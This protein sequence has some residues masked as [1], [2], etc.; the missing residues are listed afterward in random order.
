MTPADI[1]GLALKNAGV[2]GVGQTANAEDT[3]DAFTLLNMMLSQWQR[4]RWLIW[5]LV[6]TSKVSTGAQSY[7][8]G[9]GG[10]YNIARPDR[11]EAAFFRQENITLAPDYPLEILEAREDY[12]RI[13]LKNLTAFPQYIFYD[14]DFPLGRIYPWPIPQANLYSVHITTKAEL[15][16]FTS[17]SQSINLPPEY[18]AAIFYNLSV[19][20]R[21]MYQLQPD[22]TITAMA[23]DAL[24]VIRGANT[25]IPR[26]VM[27]DSLVN[28][29]VY[30]VYSDRIQ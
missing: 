30:D 13:S 3:N 16:Q 11:I 8:V 20:L 4:K 9:T 5:H 17:L 14:A 22:P 29:G 19:R 21:P 1:I 10:D 26:L 28:A 27:P 15:S 2:L 25:Q 7:T 18:F 24:N 6:T 12:N 23:K